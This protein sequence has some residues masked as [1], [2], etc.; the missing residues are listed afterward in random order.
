LNYPNI[1]SAV[2]KV[3]HGTHVPP[4]DWREVPILDGAEA[5]NMED[6]SSSSDPSYIPQSC[7]KPHLKERRQLND[8]YLQRNKQN[9]FDK[10]FNSGIC[11]LWIGGLAYLESEIRN[12]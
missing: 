6:Q 10:S 12:S 11:W 1:P 7:H 2:K 4:T 9:F 3:P 5:D 8:L